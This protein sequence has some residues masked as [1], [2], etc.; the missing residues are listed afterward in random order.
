MASRET[1]AFRARRKVSRWLASRGYEFTRIRPDD[2]GGFGENHNPKVNKLSERLARFEQGGWFESP[3]ERSLSQAVARFIG[4]AHTVVAMGNGTGVFEKFVAV[5]AALEILGLVPDADSLAWCEV[6]R[7]APQLRFSVCDPADVPDKYGEFDL[8]V[9]IGQLD[10]SI[11]FAGHLGHLSKMAGRAI[12]TVSNR[13]RDFESLVAPTPA[14]HEHVREWTAGEFYWVLRAFYSEVSL[15]AMSDPC[16]PELKAAG[17][18]CDE[19]P[20]VA[21][22]KK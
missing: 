17:L 16:V 1:I 21:V 9:S 5:D 15:Y 7:V 12:V 22:C 6:N 19:S 18:F 3:E 4:D 20:L 11:D 2:A 14:N 13:S 10:G 8:A